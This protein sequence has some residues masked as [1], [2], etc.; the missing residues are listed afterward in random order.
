MEDIK[1]LMDFFVWL[2]GPGSVVAAGFFVS[3]ILERFQFWH[4]WNHDLKTAI[5]LFMSV[6]IAYVAKYLQVDVLV[7]NEQLN[8]IFTYFINYFS[9]QIAYKKYFDIHLAAQAVKK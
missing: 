9:G 6:V 5:M 8:F 2:S 7:E 4:K 1:T 3:Y